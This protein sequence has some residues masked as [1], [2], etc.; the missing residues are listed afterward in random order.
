MPAPHRSGFVRW[1]H[2]VLLAMLAASPTEHSHA[3]NALP[4][5]DVVKVRG[6]APMSGGEDPN[7]GALAPAR[8]IE[9]DALNEADRLDEAFTETGW[10]TWSAANST[11]IAQGLNV[12]GFVFSDQS[13]T[14]LQASRALINGHADIAW[15]FMRDPA[16]LESARL[17]G[18]TDATL[19]GAGGPGSALHMLTKAGSTAPCCRRAS[20]AMARAASSPMPSARP[21]PCRCVASPPCIP[22]SAASTGWSTATRPPC[23]PLVCH[24]ATTVLPAICNSISNTTATTNPTASAFPTRPDASGSIAATSIP[25]TPTPTAATPVRPCTGNTVSTTV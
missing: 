7:P 22:A 3:E 5:L 25:N 21:A 16:T 18:G 4:Q 14:Q 13:S 19:T 9:G 17:L 10:A 23:S 6:S 8:V 1:Q 2:I 15:R 24:M 11:G 20:P 12:R